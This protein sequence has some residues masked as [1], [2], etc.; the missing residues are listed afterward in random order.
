MINATR[1][2]QIEI[3]S[4]TPIELLGS[5]DDLI[6]T[7]THLCDAGDLV[8]KLYYVGDEDGW[9]WDTPDDVAEIVNPTTTVLDE[10][11]Y[12]VDIIGFSHAVV[13]A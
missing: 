12:Q 3:K 2:Y 9:H 5:I 13:V 6:E 4:S 1:S 7:I 11:T 8:G 10:I